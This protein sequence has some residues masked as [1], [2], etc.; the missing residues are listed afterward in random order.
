MTTQVH[1]KQRTAAVIRGGR[2]AGSCE[3]CMWQDNTWHEDD[4]EGRDAAAWSARAHLGDTHPDRVT[5][6]DLL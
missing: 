5:Y 3:F 6:W 2:I 4:R 1:Y